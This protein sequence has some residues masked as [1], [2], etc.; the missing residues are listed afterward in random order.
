MVNNSVQDDALADLSALTDPVRR[1]LY[2][3]VSTQDRPVRRD[4]AA[5]A[6]GI[7]RALAAYHLDLLAAAGLVATSYARPAGRGGPG[8]GRPAKHY[9][10]VRQEVSLSIPPRNYTLLARLLADAVAADTSGAVRSAVLAAAEGEGESSAAPERDLL[11]TLTESGYTP[12]END[13]GDIELTNCPFHQLSQ[14]QT[15]LVCGLNHALL[16][17]TL[18]GRGD[19]PDRAELAPCPGRCCVIIHPDRSAAS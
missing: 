6:T 14:R 17:G 2:A 9:E 4:D 3:Y 12:T 8:A 13:Q 7:S 15:E 1:R 19:N 16:R 10:P 18:K 5:T 11:T